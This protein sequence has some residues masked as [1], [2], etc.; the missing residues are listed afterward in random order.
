MYQEVLTVSIPWPLMRRLEF[1]ASQFEYCEYG[2]DQF[3]YKTKDNVKLSGVDFGQVTAQDTGRDKRQDIGSQT[4]NGLS[5][6]AVLT[7]LV[8]IK[9]MAYFRGNR[10]V[11][12]EDVR[13]ILPFVLHD[14]L[15]QD[16]DSPIFG[17]PERAALRLDK[18]SWIRQLFDAS[19]PHYD[20]LA[21]DSDDPL[22]ELERCFDAGLDGVTQK[23]AR[24]ELVKIE[25][26]LGELSAGRKFYGH[27]Y[28]DVLKLKYLHQRYT[29]YL[30]W[31]EWKG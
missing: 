27:M 12:L 9:A 10:E 8:F 18:I 20:R 21:L 14:K 1:F 30:R 31:L 15:L 17:T 16:G 3:E 22:A 28:D 26:L 29:N 25:R 4:R 13:Q 7:A 6:R 11:A 5:V 2:A 24:A 23:Q 19:S